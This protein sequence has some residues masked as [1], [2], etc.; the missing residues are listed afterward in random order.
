MRLVLPI[1][2]TT[3]ALTLG[4]AGSS[5]SPASSA[6]PG[7]QSTA[8][9]SVLKQGTVGTLEFSLDAAG[10]PAVALADRTGQFPVLSNVVTVKLLN[11]HYSGEHRTWAMEIAIT[12]HTPLTAF[13]PVATFYD[14]NGNTILNADGYF[15]LDG[16]GD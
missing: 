2:L 4:C 5:T 12:N 1:L 14:L 15:T 16:G 8:A 11:A 9:E 6:L 7:T 10:K 13:G 3:V